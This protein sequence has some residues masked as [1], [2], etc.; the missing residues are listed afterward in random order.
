[1][2]GTIDALVDQRMGRL[3]SDLQSLIQQPSVSAKKQGLV[4]CANLVAKIMQAAGINSQVLYLEDKNVPPIVYGEIKSKSKSNKTILFYN[5]YDVQPEEPLELWDSEPFSGKIEGNYIFGRGSADDKGELITRIK[6]VEYFLEKNGDVPCNVK[7]LIEGE[8]EIGSVHI[9]QYLKKYQDRL[10]C[11]GVIWEF[12]YVNAKDQPIISL[13]MKGLLYVELIAKE[14]VRDVHSSLAVL[15]ENPAWRLIS[16]LNTM[17]DKNG[18]ILIK[19]WYN[20][21][22]P[23]TDQE[24]EVIEKEPFEEIEFKKEYGIRRFVA[25]LQGIEVKKA[26]VGMPTCNIAGFNSGYIGEGAK[27]VLPSQATV[28]ID[29]RLVPDMIPEMQ[30]E[31]LKAHLKEKGFEDIEVKFIHGEAAARTSISNPF[32][33][34]V[35]QAANET[36]GSSV[37]SVS[38]AGTGPMYPFV[39]F[40][41]APCISVGSTY[42]FARIHSPNE[43]AR[44]DLLNKTTKCIG[45]II[46]KFAA[47]N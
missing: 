34:Q 32:V 25:N 12:G 37:I 17:R 9:E 21:A 11:D 33:E 18:R 23:F 41:Q 29:F 20:E 46:E 6:A 8:E 22:R 1:L 16:L 3:I 2:N 35:V 14:P 26:L 5:H 39:K 4:E 43:F 40:L 7:F 27:T 15:V 19:D 47:S 45:R 31:R 44:I 28:K 36:F 38:S 13:G 24:L 30:L 42:M 10:K